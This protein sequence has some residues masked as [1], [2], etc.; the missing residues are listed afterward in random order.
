MESFNKDF[1]NNDGLQS[2]ANIGITEGQYIDKGEKNMFKGD[3]NFSEI[4][5]QTIFA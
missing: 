1:S 2:R 5:S 3:S 4:A